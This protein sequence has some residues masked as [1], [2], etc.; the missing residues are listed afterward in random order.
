MSFSIVN[1]SITTK[2]NF[3]FN[4]TKTFSDTLNKYFFSNEFHREFRTST[5]KS[6]DAELNIAP[7]LAVARQIINA[8]GQ[9]GR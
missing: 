4:L 5:P 8:S 7:R 9:F 3:R 6:A 1:N 2:Y